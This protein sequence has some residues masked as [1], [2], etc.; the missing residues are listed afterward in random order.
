MWKKLSIA[1][2][3]G[4]II[5]ILYLFGKQLPSK[6]STNIPS[7]ITNISSQTGDTSDYASNPSGDNTTTSS[8]NVTIKD[9]VQYIVIDVK[10]G[11]SPRITEAKWDIPTKLIAKTNETYD[12][13]SSLVIRSIGYQSSLPATWETTVDLGTPKSGGTLDA[14]CGMG[15]YSFQINFHT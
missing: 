7:Q 10:Q 8:S 9:G 5:G 15:M 4:L 6:K 1:I 2:S 11:Y 13:S 12:C 14:T 3:L